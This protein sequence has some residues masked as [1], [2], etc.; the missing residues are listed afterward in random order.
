LSLLNPVINAVLAEHVETGKYDLFIVFFANGADE[1][2]LD[3]LELSLIEA[4]VPLTDA[5][6]LDPLLAPEHAI[7]VRQEALGEVA[8]ECFPERLEALGGVRVLGLQEEEVL[9]G[10]GEGG[11]EHEALALGE[12]ERLG[13]LREA[14]FLEGQGREEQGRGVGL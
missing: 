4:V 1:L 10:G 3:S 12:G 7:A 14:G 5:L 2:V 9:L 8:P 13:L 6:H 11:G